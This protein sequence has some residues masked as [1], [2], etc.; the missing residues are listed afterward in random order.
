MTYI[1]LCNSRRVVCFELVLNTFSENHLKTVT[2]KTHVVRDF[3]GERLFLSFARLGANPTFRWRANRRY[4]LKFTHPRAKKLIAAHAPY[5]YASG[6][7]GG[8]DHGVVAMTSRA[9]HTYAAPVSV[10][11]FDVVVTAAAKN[12]KFNDEMRAARLLGRRG[13][14]G[15]GNYHAVRS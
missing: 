3:R 9:P 10:T 4:A 1:T 2:L 7:A 5:A 12:D 11:R 6:I 15:A 14:D 8:I 13:A